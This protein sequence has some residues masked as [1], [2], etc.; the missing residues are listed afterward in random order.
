MLGLGLGVESVGRLGAKEAEDDTDGSQ[1]PPQ[2]KPRLSLF[3]HYMDRVPAD[4]ED[5][6]RLEKILTH[7]NVIDTINS[8]SVDSDSELA[9]ICSQMEFVPLGYLLERILAVPAS[10]AHVVR[11]FL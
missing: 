7:Y 10:S 8:V 6:R 5:S 9:D 3:S 2:K 1:P 4:V 11:V